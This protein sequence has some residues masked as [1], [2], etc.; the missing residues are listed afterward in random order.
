M[1]EIIIKQ[2]V[3][4]Q[5]L[6]VF[7]EHCLTFGTPTGNPFDTIECGNCGGKTNQWLIP[8]CCALNITFPKNMRHENK[9]ENKS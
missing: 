2:H 8:I 4:T 5:S 6:H 1:N 3:H 7:C 9:G